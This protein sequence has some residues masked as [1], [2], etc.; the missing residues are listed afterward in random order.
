MRSLTDIQARL[1]DLGRY[2]GAVDGVDGPLTRAAVA[3][4]QRDRGLVADG[5]PG[6]VTQSHLFPEPPIP[7][8][9]RD[10]DPPRAEPADIVPIWP[11]Q[12]EVE[13]VFGAP[14]GHQTLLTPPYPMRL[15]WQTRT[16][17]PRFSIH[18]MCHDSALRCLTRVAD[19]YDAA[20]RADLGLD[21]WG[22]CLNV[23]PMRGGARLS[24]HAWG[25]AI[26]F[27]PDRNALTWGADRARL[28]RPDAATFWRIWAE[29][30]W[31]GLGRARDYDWMHVQAA[32]L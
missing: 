16:P 19:A 26:D 1:T 20:A 6:P 13:R 25:I 7:A 18:E 24:M 2:D 28:A 32:R 27:D 12:A 22:G 3:A 30:G 14:G 23:R 31:V 29:E 11:R 17:V 21:L 8:L 10:I 4:F 15:A 5:L 9:E